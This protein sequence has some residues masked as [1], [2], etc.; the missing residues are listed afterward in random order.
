MPATVY[1]KSVREMI[2]HA[3]HKHGNNDV[4]DM[5]PFAGGMTAEEVA[6]L[7]ADQPGNKEAGKDIDYLR[8]R[9]IRSEN[10]VPMTLPIDQVFPV[11]IPSGRTESQTVGPIIV[12]IN[13]RKISQIGQDGKENGFVPPTLDID[14]QHRWYDAKK[15]GQKEI[16]ALVGDLAVPE[17]KKKMGPGFFRSAASNAVRL[18]EKLGVNKKYERERYARQLFNKLNGPMFFAGQWF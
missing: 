10:F 1:E 4:R 17:L 14:G 13:F 12:E 8:G 18:A 15:N 3:Y 11:K 16:Q 7:L 9:W 2:H 5:T 6:V